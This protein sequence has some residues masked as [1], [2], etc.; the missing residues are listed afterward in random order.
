LASNR[1]NLAVSSVL[2]SLYSIQTLLLSRLFTA[3]RFT[4]LRIAGSALAL[5]GVAAISAA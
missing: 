3:E 1:G 2:A 5:T 4:R